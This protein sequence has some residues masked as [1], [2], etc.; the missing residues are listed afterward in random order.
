MEHLTTRKMGSSGYCLFASLLIKFMIFVPA[1]NARAADSAN[2]VANPGFERGVN[3]QGIPV[4]WSNASSYLAS[5][6]V[7]S[8]QRHSGSYSLQCST[9]AGTGYQSCSSDFIPVQGGSPYL[10]SVW[11]KSSG[12]EYAYFGWKEFDSNFQELDSDWMDPFVL[13]DQN[14]PA[15][16]TQFSDV[17]W[18]NANSSYVKIFSYAPYLSAGTIWIDDVNLVKLDTQLLP[19]IGVVNSKVARSIDF[20]QSSLPGDITYA[21]DALSA[22]LYEGN[23]NYQQILPCKTLVIGFPAFNIDAN[24]FPL[25]PLALEIRYKDTISDKVEAG[26]PAHRSFVYSVIDFTSTDP[27]FH[28][29][30]DYIYYRLGDLDG[31]SDG[32]WKYKQIVF[33]KSPFQLIRA[34]G[35]RFT[36]RIEMPQD[37]CCQLPLDYVTLASITQS[38]CDQMLQRG[39]LL[40]G[41]IKVSLPG[42]APANP[43]KYSSLTIF[44]RDPMR[45][46][47]KFTKPA[48]GEITTNV[49]GFSAK[50]TVEPLNF[51]IYS[52]NGVQNLSFQF[53]DLTNTQTN[54]VIKANQLSLWHVVCDN[55]RLTPYCAKNRFANI[56][57]RIE[58]VSLLSIDANT[59]ERLWVKIAVPSNVQAGLYSGSIR[60][61]QSGA[62]S[63]TMTISM[64]VLPFALQTTGNFYPVY[65]DPYAQVICS[66]SNEVY[67]L[68]AEAG[69]DPFIYVTSPQ[70]TPIVSAGVITGFDS[71]RF[72]TNLQK[73]IE[74]RFAKNMVHVETLSTWEAIYETIYNIDESEIAADPNLFYR[75]SD[76]RFVNAFS[77]AISKYLQIGAALGVSMVFSVLDEPEDDPCKRIEAERLFKIVHNNG[78]LTTVTY[79]GQCDKPVAPGIFGVPMDNGYGGMIPPLTGSV[80]YKIWGLSSMLTGFQE[81]PA[82]FGYYTTGTSH[83]RNPLYNRFLHGLMAFRT[84]AGIVSACAMA[85]WR[86]DPYNDFDADSAISSFV[87]PDFLFA[88]PTWQ[89][90]LLP[91]MNFEGIREGMKDAMYITT[92]KQLISAKQ[93]DPVSIEASNYLNA[94]KQQINPDYW[95]A[96]VCKSDDYGFYK[97]ILAGISDSNNPDDF[98]SFTKIR[99]KIADYIV[100]LL[101]CTL[102][103]DDFETGGLTAG[104]WTTQNSY[105]SVTG[106]AAYSGKYGVQLAQS[107]WIQKSMST[108][109]YNTI[110]VKY[111][112][113]T[114]GMGSKEWFYAEWS[115]DGKTWNNLETTHDTVWSAEDFLC[116]VGA[117]NNANFRIRF[118]TSAGS[119]SKYACVDN[120]VITGT[121]L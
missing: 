49:S 25:T 22:P 89:G 43:P 59:S 72:E 100:L 19:P 42:D 58:P 27:L 121:K 111:N 17:S 52:K 78:A 51:A 93:T 109:G 66:D 76:G 31:T 30:S 47:Y 115:V 15:A 107:T 45:P 113:K 34:L 69:F 6:Q 95:D 16:W 50:G 11:L 24:G 10:L 37:P 64:N 97:S 9:T 120:C 55:K 4:N 23:I 87:Y 119:T 92:L 67:N 83:L 105:V 61:L 21:A 112:R 65:Y 41:F 75:L 91:A 63:K 33:Q 108:V 40:N 84:G 79:S 114:K 35:G 102:F 2:L 90:K 82:N 86:G 54:T 28:G 98:E 38:Q 99:K 110:H 20:G 94:L 74:K 71:S 3:Q 26:Y 80:D 77:M 29:E 68:Y 12:N 57:D 118:R 103:T 48:S 1:G 5:M 85:D 39:W 46:I 104:K 73:M 117:G 81:N 70:F 13:S 14:V 96:Y 7:V 56:P 62:L 101:A 36:I 32:K 106:S 44:T 8:T 116:D 18:T 60:V 88:Y 53:S